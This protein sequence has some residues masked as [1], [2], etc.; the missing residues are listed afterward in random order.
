MKSV[1]G[2]SSDS[3]SVLKQAG[4]HPQ[5]MFNFTLVGIPKTSRLV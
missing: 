5:T 4:F 2:K 3:R 1:D